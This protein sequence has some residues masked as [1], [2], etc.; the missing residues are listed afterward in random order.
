MII[1]SL[2]KHQEIIWKFD[3]KLLKYLKTAKVGKEVHSD[4]YDGVWSLSILPNGQT[5]YAGDCLIGLSLCSLPEQVEKIK[6][7]RQTEILQ[8][9]IKNTYTSDFDY[10]HSGSSL[11]MMSFKD[12]QKLDEFTIKMTIDILNIYDDPVA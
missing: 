10:D 1:C 8:N 5:G 4:I 6:L 12:F 11:K 7:K 3:Q 9:N 2:K